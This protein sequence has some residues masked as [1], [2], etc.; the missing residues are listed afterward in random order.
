MS[1]ALA[2]YNGEADAVKTQLQSQLD[3]LQSAKPA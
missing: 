1:I 2:L 3:D